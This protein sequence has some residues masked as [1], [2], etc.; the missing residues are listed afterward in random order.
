M[1]K[2]EEDQFLG[3]ERDFPGGKLHLHKTLPFAELI[4]ANS[5]AAHFEHPGVYF[6]HDKGKGIVFYVKCNWFN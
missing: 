4:K 6:E 2:E 5:R 1:E 3:G